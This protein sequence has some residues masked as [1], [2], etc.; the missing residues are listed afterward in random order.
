MCA[1]AAEPA[2]LSGEAVVIDGDT[3]RIGETV[4]RLADIDAPELAQV[5]DGGAAPL[6]SCG[7]YVADALA[8]R[9]RG[10]DV[11]CT[12]LGIDDYD[13][14]IATCEVAGEDLSRW[15]VS[16]GLTMAFRR[17]STSLVADEDI[18]REAG[19]GLWQT[20]FEAPWDY[21]AKRWEVAVQAAPEGCP[22]KGNVNGEGK[23]HLP[24]TLGVAVVRQD[25]DQS[26]S[27]RTLVLF[28]TP[29]AGRWLASAIAIGNRRRSR[30]VFAIDTR[31]R[32]GQHRENK[33]RT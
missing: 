24:H 31:D 7:A 1:G 29:R 20:D 33:H 13:R 21:R 16:R 6:L 27:R 4:V 28:G 8:E 30:G 14:R 9:I 23:T 2:T 10:H 26:Q 12:V 11:H 3:F 18:A 17:Y 19:T 5:C 32:T 22:V 15:L 25:Q